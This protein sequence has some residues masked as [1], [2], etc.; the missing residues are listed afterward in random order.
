MS[1]DLA[2]ANKEYIVGWDAHLTLF[3][4]LKS[5]FFDVMPIWPILHN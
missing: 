2:Y 1:S 4:Q 5:A 3:T